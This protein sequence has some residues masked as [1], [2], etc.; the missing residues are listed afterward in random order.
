MI[1]QTVFFILI[2]MFFSAAAA[3]KNSSYSINWKLAAVL[4]PL[5][6]QSKS[7]GFAGAINGVDKDAFIIAGG[8]NFP[9]GM[10]WDGGK[11]YYSDEIWVLQKSGE[12]YFWN[13]K[14]KDILPEPIAYCGN[15]STDTGVVYVGG[16]NKNGISNKSF[17]LNWDA[18]KNK[19][20][21]KPLPDLPVALTNV[22]VTHIENIVYAAGGDEM[23]N[24]SA[25]FFSI[26]LNDPNPQW[27]RLPDL[28]VALANA[29]AIAQSGNDGK[30][31]FIIGG[32]TKT[33]SGISDLHN[34]IFIFDPVKQSWKKGADIFDGKNTTN[35]SAA[36]GVALGANEILMLGGDNGKVFHQ[37]ETY[38]SE[39]EQAK[40]SEQKEK[41]TKE[42]NSLSIHHKGFDKSLLVY[43]TISDAWTK[44]GELTFPA[45]VTT[46]AV[47]W[48]NDIVVSNG[49]IKPGVRTPNVVIGLEIIGHKSTKHKGAQRKRS[50]LRN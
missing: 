47:K 45:Q 8:A 11:K 19:I 35:L 44:I 43:N 50:N 7:L 16:E 10:P 3:Q 4:P 38:I 15:T 39:I 40:T 28:P 49:E 41:L 30:E 20:I 9:N 26:N 36:S 27:K 22:A 13:K 14:V 42:K 2:I 37:I 21:I 1:R 32:R 24:S 23:K 18:T 17:L 33:A 31:I 6:G 12:K 34:T 46:T 25:S 29:T 5:P 48:G